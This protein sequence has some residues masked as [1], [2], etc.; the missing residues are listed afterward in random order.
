MRL[1]MKIISVLILILIVGGCSLITDFS[2]DDSNNAN[3]SNNVNNVNNVNNNLVELCNNGIDDN[4]DNHIDCDDV[5]C[6]GSEFCICSEFDFFHDSTKKCDFKQECVP[7]LD[8]M[9]I[10]AQCIDDAFTA[11]GEYY[12]Y[13]GPQGECPLGSFCLFDGALY[14]HE[15]APVCSWNHPQCFDG[16][17]PALFNNEIDHDQVTVCMMINNC[18]IL[19]GMND[20]INEKSCAM[21]DADGDTTAC[22]IPG[23]MQVFEQCTKEE[24]CDAGLHCLFT[25]GEENPGVCLKYCDP[26]QTA[27]CG[28]L[29]ITNA[30]CQPVFENEIG[31][32]VDPTWD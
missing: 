22:L 25:E 5:Q 31:L 10:S 20:C 3:N 24:R 30:V 12:N 7:F 11:E 4:D 27:N 14:N 23:P 21:L 32:C 6:N 26:G 2:E 28:G 16:I 19:N 13:C 15:C 9:R 18:E 17:C 29:G 8:N 1:N